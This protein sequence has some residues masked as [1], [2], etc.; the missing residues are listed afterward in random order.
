MLRDESSPASA[1]SA[2]SSGH[3][4]G[5]SSSSSSAALDAATRPG[6]L[7]LLEFKVHSYSDADEDE[8][9]FTCMVLTSEV[10]AGSFEPLQLPSASLT[11][12]QLT[13]AHAT[14]LHGSIALNKYFNKEP[15]ASLVPCTIFT[16]HNDRVLYTAAAA[17]GDS[18]GALVLRGKTLV[19]MHTEWLNDVPSD[20]D[21]TSP[22]GKRGRPRKRIKLSEASPSTTGTALRLDLPQVRDAVAA[23]HAHAQDLA[24]ARGVA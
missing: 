20:Y 4:A 9:D 5:S 11:T 13:G 14:L 1:A 17:D 21:V 23:A 22:S 6:E 12:S 8:L 19:G 24:V 2:A 18:G 10:P 7:K 15:S 3:G 16:T